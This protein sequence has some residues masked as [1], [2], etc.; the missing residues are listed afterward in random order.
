MVSRADGFK[1]NPQ[2]ERGR[3]EVQRGIAL[4]HAAGYFC[5]VESGF[6]RPSNDGEMLTLSTPGNSERKME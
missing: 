2:R 4:A 1:S 3:R 6:S 5:G